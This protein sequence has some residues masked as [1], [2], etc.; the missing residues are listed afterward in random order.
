MSK[1]SKACQINARSAR[2]L[3]GRLPRIAL[4]RLGELTDRYS[5]SIASGDLLFLEGRWYVTHAGLLHLA[6][7]RHCVGIRVQ[8]VRQ[9]CD[10]AAGRWVFKAT[11]YK[12][13]GSQ[14]FVGFGD[15]DP[16]N[17]SPLVRGA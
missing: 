12:R 7:R 15:A 14:G 8:Q 4:R 10:P 2:E 11:L 6:Q 5:L 3:W 13:A 16:S 9:F 1:Q 17:T